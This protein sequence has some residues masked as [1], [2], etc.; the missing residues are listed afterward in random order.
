MDAGNYTG[1]EVDLF[2]PGIARIRFNQPDRLN[3][4]NAPMKRDLVEILL[5]AQLDNAVRV[6][7]FTGS[8]R[9]FCAGDSLKDY[10]QG[11]PQR[12]LVP[13]IPP[14]HDTA[15]GTY[16][17]LRG[18]SQPVNRAIR[19]LDKL[20][21][22]AVNGIAIQSGFSLALACDF[23]LAA[24]SAR[25]GSATLRFGLLPD[26]GGQYLLVQHLGVARTIDFLLRKRIV[27]AEC[28]LELGLVHE[29]T[30][31]DELEKRSMDLAIEL[32]TGP[33]VSMRLLKRSIYNAAELGFAQSLDE[34]AAKTG[35]V[36]HHE[37]AR[38]GVMAFREKREP[39]FNRW[40]DQD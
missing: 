10:A 18:I 4:M 38:E 30:E 29:V 26:E 3:G 35:I 27:D 5:Q 1:F 12:G 22:A 7:L 16:D 21:I 19:D 28:A 15:I 31:D 13:P 2:D 14:G 11:G 24:R 6:V 33:Q 20:S 39:R 23:R 36:D 37:D 34:I 9:A 40:L 8:G 25:L 17:G 32:A